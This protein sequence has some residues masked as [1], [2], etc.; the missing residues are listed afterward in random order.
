MSCA[1]ISYL[2]DFEPSTEEQR[3]KRNTKVI[4]DLSELEAALALARSGYIVSKP[5]GDSHRYDLV[6]DDGERLSR[7]QVKTGRLRGGSIRFN[8]YSSHSHRGG[9]ASRSYHGEVD[10]IAVY[11][12]QTGKAYLT[13]EAELVNTQMHLRVDPTVNRQD[14]HIRWATRY[15]LP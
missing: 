15:E 1:T 8:C 2:F 4:G 11:C 10:F 6:I 3:P 12:P 13:P 5:L 9:S 7:V 14:W